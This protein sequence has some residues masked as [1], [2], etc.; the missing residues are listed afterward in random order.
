MS[1]CNDDLA[2]FCYSASYTGEGRCMGSAPH[3]AADW[4]N[5]FSKV[6][7]VVPSQPASRTDATMENDVDLSR[8]TG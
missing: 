3:H 2:L 5:Q 8:T 7:T 1:H 4:T 6:R